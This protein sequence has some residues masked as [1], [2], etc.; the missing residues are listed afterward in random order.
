MSNLPREFAEYLRTKGLSKSSIRNYIADLTKFLNWFEVTAGEEF[1]PQKLDQNYID[2]YQKYLR[3]YGL[4]ETSIRR[5]LA[6]IK[7]LYSWIRPHINILPTITSQA[8]ISIPSDIENKASI[9]KLSV[10]SKADIIHSF[11]GY[12]QNQGLSKNS[13]RNYLADFSK[14]FDWYV[15]NNESLFSLEKINIELINYYMEK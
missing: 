14:F 11:S 7:Q 4:P 5:S 6:T 10:N 2:Q 3:E 13:I 12:L 15:K 9:N 1:S 8:E